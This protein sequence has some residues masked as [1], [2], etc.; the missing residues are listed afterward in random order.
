MENIPRVLDRT[1]ETRESSGPHPERIHV[2]LADQNRTGT[3][4]TTDNGCVLR[5]DAI[6]KV[7]EGRRGRKAFRVIEVLHGDGDAVQGPTPMALLDVRLRG[8]RGTPGALRV[9]RDECIQARVE[10]G[11]LRQ[12]GIHDG[13]GRQAGFPN[14]RAQIG[15]SRKQ[16]ILH[17]RPPGPTV[18]NRCPPTDLHDLLSA[19]PCSPP[20]IESWNHRV[21]VTWSLHLGPRW[22]PIAPFGA[23]KRVLGLEHLLLAES[24]HTC[25]SPLFDPMRQR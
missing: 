10:R 18:P 8:D 23:L 4:E 2:R 6:R 24:R 17:L 22:Y 20:L 7:L 5:R 13:Y 12:A 11:D 21:M 9:D 15:D 25:H 3:L 14:A 19:T 1:K 16:K